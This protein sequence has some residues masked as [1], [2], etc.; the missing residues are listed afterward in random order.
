MKKKLLILFTIIMTFTLCGCGTKE[1]SNLVE[2]TFDELTK[3]VENKEDF[4]LVIESDQCSACTIYMPTMEKVVKNYNVKV[5]YIN[6]RVLT[7]EQSAKLATYVYTNST[8]LTV[9]FK[10]GV[11]SDTHNRIVGAANYDAVVE[12]FTKNGYIGK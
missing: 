10:E 3:K 9:Y 1:E 8:P 4:I 2:L 5:N 7:D 12:S 11:A 6:I